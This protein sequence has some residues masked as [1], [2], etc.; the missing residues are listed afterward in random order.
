MSSRPQFNPYPVILD[1]DMSGS[2]TSKIT[3]IQKLSLVSYE[4]TWA[5]STPVGTISVEVSN[6]YTQNDDGSVRNAGSWSALP[7]SA[8]TSVSG[9]TGTGFIDVYACGAYAMRLVYTRVS[10]TGTMQAIVSAKVA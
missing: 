1:G 5:G 6:D 2:L 3:I 4:I 9:N 8:D 7:L 10:G